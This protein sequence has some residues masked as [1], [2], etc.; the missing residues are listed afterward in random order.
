[1][2]INVGHPEGSDQLEQVL[3]RDAARGLPDV[4]RDPVEPTNTLLVGA[5]TPRLGRALRAAAPLPPT[6]RPVAREAATGSSPACRGGD[7]YTDD[8]RRSSGWS[9]PRS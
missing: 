8:R 7:V 1:M 5:A 9:T 2:L 3:T 6:L 4:V